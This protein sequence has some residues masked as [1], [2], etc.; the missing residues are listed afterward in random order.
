[1]SEQ[2]RAL[3]YDG[4]TIAGYFLRAHPNFQYRELFVQ[5]LLEARRAFLNECPRASMVVSAEALLRVVFDQIV[6][7]ATQHG[8]ATVLRGPNS[9]LS[10]DAATDL[11]FDLPEELNFCKALKIIE[12]MKAFPEVIIEQMYVVKDLR[13][14]A[15]HGDLPLL[16]T[17]EPPVARE[18]LREMLSNSD[19]DVPEAYRFI[20]RKGSGKWYVFR[21]QDHTCGTLRPLSDEER[22]AAI[23]YLI[24][25]SIL[26]H[27]I[28]SCP[29]DFDAVLS[30]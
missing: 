7:L 6:K 26:K 8:A 14:R 27:I 11:L 10:D 1:M 13:N 21:L 3:P 15:V 25:L 20:A 19:W 29:S 2:E 9:G 5:L 18:D 24:V 16:D 17:W 23:Q 28:N 22:F 12:R 30:D 4:K